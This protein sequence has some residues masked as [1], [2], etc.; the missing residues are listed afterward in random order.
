MMGRWNVQASR[1]AHAAP[2]IRYQSRD[3]NALI[4]NTI[5]IS[6][7][8]AGRTQKPDYFIHNWAYGQ[9]KIS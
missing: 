4:T 6:G 7:F 3:A 1:Y 9:G 8:W 5:E 2:E